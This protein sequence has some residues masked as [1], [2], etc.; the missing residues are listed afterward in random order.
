MK[1]LNFSL[2]KVILPFK[3]PIQV[4]KHKLHTKTSLYLTLNFSGGF[5][6]TGEISLLPG[7]I[8]LTPEEA[9][10]EVQNFLTP[11]QGLP[12]DVK[13]LKMTRYGLKRII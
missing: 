3:K 1:L 12:L 4:G 13:D 11:L 2:K 5:S 6:G 9:K 8:D 10:K 7:L